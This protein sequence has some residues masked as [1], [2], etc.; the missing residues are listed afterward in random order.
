MYLKHLK[1]YSEKWLQRQCAILISGYKELCN[2]IKETMC[3]NEKEK[4]TCNLCHCVSS[5]KAWICVLEI[6]VTMMF[7][8]NS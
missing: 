3:Q 4:K 2:G 8:V 6:P 7:L 5:V 1:F